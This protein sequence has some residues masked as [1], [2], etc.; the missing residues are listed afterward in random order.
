MENK[1]LHNNDNDNNDK[2][3]IV[4]TYEEQNEIITLLCEYKQKIIFENHQVELDNELLG[5]DSQIHEYNIYK[6]NRIIDRITN[7]I[8]KICNHVWVDDYI[9]DMYGNTKRIN[10]CEFCE[11]TKNL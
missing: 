3:N 5:Y 4:L 1:N 8:G 9:D 6:N 10:Y 2:K 11:T 7:A